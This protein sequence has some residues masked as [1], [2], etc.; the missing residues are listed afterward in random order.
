MLT[1]LSKIMSIRKALKIRKQFTIEQN[2]FLKEQKID[3]ENTAAGWIDFLEELAEFDTYVDAAR[4]KTVTIAIV[5]GVLSF[6][7]IFLTAFSGGLAAPLLI[8]LIIATITYTAIYF[9][10]KKIDIPNRMRLFV[11]P[12]IRVLQEE[13]KDESKIYLK[14]DFT[15]GL[16]K[17]Y[18]TKH[19]EGKYDSNAK[20][21]VDLTFYNYPV[22]EL[23]AKLADG[24]N[25]AIEIADIARK[26]SIRKTNYRGK[27]KWKTKYKIKTRI[28]VSLIA[29]DTAYQYI[30]N[31]DKKPQ[32]NVKQ[33]APKNIKSLSH[34]E[35]KNDKHVVSCRDVKIS[36]EEE[37]VPKLDA[38]L[39]AIAINYQKLKPVA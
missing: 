35:R 30:A 39:N 29:K 24:T 5:C 2:Q 20:K 25:L 13:M 32:E 36:T 34:Y 4:D 17:P 1:K 27:T 14:V 22:L 26:N 19:I 18:Q 3:G 11:F 38:V 15:T 9:S 16:T 7:S 31:N 37:N 21:K 10:L 33:N 6:I 23:K 12:L 28:D 8:L